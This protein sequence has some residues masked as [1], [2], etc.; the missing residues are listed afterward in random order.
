MFNPELKNIYSPVVETELVKLADYFETQNKIA[1]VN[2]MNTDCDKI[3]APMC[4]IVESRDNKDMI[5]VDECGV[6]YAKGLSSEDKEM[7]GVL[8]YLTVDQLKPT[9]ANEEMIKLWVK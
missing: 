9:D 5:R 8:I 7:L 6:N 2:G 3:V 1:Y 4:I